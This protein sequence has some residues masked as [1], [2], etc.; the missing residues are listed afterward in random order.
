LAARGRNPAANATGLLPSPTENS[1]AL[2]IR[3]TMRNQAARG[4]A[5]LNLQFG[6]TLGSWTTVTI[7]EGNRLTHGIGFVITPDGI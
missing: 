6:T 7:P 1:G 4:S 2:E 5:V 3:F